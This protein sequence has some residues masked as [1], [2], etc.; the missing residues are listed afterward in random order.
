VSLRHA[1]LAA[2][3]DGEASGYQLAKLFDV[4]VS[5]FWYATSQQ[6][7]VE[8][9]KLAADGLVSGREVLQRGRPN[10]RVFVITGAGRAELAA[11]IERA[12]KPSSIRDDLLV[13]VQALEA[14]DAL[15]LAEQLDERAAQAR[16]KVV[17][18]DHI[19][20]RLRGDL[21]EERFLLE[22]ARVGPY[23]TCRRGRS[24]EQENADWCTWAAGVMRARAN[25]TPDDSYVHPVRQAHR[26]G[27]S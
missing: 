4:S 8:L 23:L 6:L 25:A 9:T 3:L 5:N 20:A 14:G 13:K 15:A 10:K 27:T 21:D 22:G 11:F 24:F 12:S 16:S 2:L 17:L 26:V 18:F 7:Y 1:A 19:L